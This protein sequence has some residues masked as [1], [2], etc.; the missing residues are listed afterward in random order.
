MEAERV[1]RHEDDERSLARQHLVEAAIRYAL[2]TEPNDH[3][4]DRALREAVAE[5]T[6][7]ATLAGGEAA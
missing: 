6:R 3:P 7:T 2:A 5:L 4:V 1:D